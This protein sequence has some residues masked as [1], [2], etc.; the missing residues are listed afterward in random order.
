[1][2]LPLFPSIPRTGARC[3]IGALGVVAAMFITTADAETYSVDTSA[4][5]PLTGLWWNAAESGWGATLTQQSWQ[6]FVTVFVYDPSGNP[7]WLTVSCTL[8]GNSC[9]GDVIRVRGGAAPTMPWDG[10]ITTAKAGSMTLTFASD[11]A[12]EMRYTLDGA[13][14]TKQIVRQR[15]GPPLAPAPSLSGTWF[16]SIIEARTNCSKPQNVGNHATYGQYD[17][18]LG[19]PAQPTITIALYGVTGLLCTYNGTYTTNG[20]RFAASGT[21]SCN[22]GKHGTWQSTSIVVLP[23]TMTMELNGTLD[24]TETCV[25]NS[26]INAARL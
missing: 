6:L 9:S 24:T 7:A 11:D 13:T 21:T 10:G 2:R 1:M 25:V 23:R 5:S 12:A 3:L 20:T 4:A 15:F 14:A 19:S 17:V 16:G 22:D 26:L 8:A 18:V